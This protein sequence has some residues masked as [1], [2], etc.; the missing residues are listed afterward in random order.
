MSWYCARQLTLAFVTLS[1]LLG[2]VSPVNIKV[3][4]YTDFLNVNYQAELS[5][6]FGSDELVPYGKVWIVKSAP[7]EFKHWENAKL[8]SKPYEFLYFSEEEN[9]LVRKYKIAVYFARTLMNSYGDVNNTPPHYL[10][11]F[12]CGSLLSAALFEITGNDLKLVSKELFLDQGGSW[13]NPAK[14]D[15]G[16]IRSI[17]DFSLTVSDAAVHTGSYASYSYKLNYKNG[18]WFQT[19]YVS[20]TS[21]IDDIENSSPDLDEEAE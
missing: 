14:V 8:A 1:L 15:F 11:C 10:D 19:N 12:V 20:E 5:L 4:P 18:H 16:E 2:C 9:G 21:R 7:S 13:G 17:N 3:L 6:V